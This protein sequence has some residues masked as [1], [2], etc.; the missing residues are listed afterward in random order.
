MVKTAALA[1]ILSN[2][3]SRKKKSK[4]KA[5]KNNLYEE[6]EEA[7]L[8][9]GERNRRPLATRQIVDGEFPGG[10]CSIHGRGR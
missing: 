4:S 1:V 7:D 9:P 10:T 5:K 3:E 2:A 8:G 6:E